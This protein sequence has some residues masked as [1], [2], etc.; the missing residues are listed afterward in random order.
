MTWH[1]NMNSKLIKKKKKVY[2]TYS[3]NLTAACILCE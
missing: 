3:C 2:M 1:Y